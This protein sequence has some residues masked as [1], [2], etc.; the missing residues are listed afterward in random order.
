MA[1]CICKTPISSI[2]RPLKI[3]PNRNIWFEKMPSGNPARSLVMKLPKNRVPTKIQDVVWKDSKQKLSRDKKIT[4]GKYIDPNTH[5]WH[6]CKIMI[7]LLIH[8]CMLHTETK[9]GLKM[10]H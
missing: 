6:Q 7:Q 4:F 10:Y 1:I 9:F 8:I 5:V 2:V 3:Y